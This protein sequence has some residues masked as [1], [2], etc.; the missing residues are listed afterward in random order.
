METDVALHKS[1]EETYN[2]LLIDQACLDIY[3]AAVYCPITIV[4]AHEDIKMETRMRNNTDDIVDD[5]H[6]Y[7]SWSRG[8]DSVLFYSCWSSII[9]FT[10]FGIDRFVAV[11]KPMW[12]YT[13]VQKKQSIPNILL[14][15]QACLDIYNAA[16]YCPVTIVIAHEDIKMETRMR[17]NNRQ[18]SGQR[19]CIRQLE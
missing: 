12:H 10:L 11:W 7:D 5:V 4:I 16:V 3:N 19:A 9:G 1:T 6:A 8:M 18:H 14:I 15:N 2:I 17:N 13:R